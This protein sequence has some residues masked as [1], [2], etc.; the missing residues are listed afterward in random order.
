MLKVP[1]FVEVGVKN[2]VATVW[3]ILVVLNPVGVVHGGGEQAKVVNVPPIDQALVML[4]ET[5][6]H[7]VC[8]CHS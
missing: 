5:L 2:N 4:G 3:V 7:T 8:A 6:L 1:T